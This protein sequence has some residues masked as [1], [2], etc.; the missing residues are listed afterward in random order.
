MIGRNAVLRIPLLATCAW[1]LVS[2]SSDPDFDLV[3]RGGTVYDGTGEASGIRRADV[4]IAG[5]RIR[6]IGDLGTRTARESVDATGRI[7]APG[8]IDAQSRSGLTLLADGAGESH[9]RQGI[10]SEILSDNSPAPWTAATADTG[11]LRRY[12]ITLDWMGLGGY[13]DRLESRGTAINV[14]SLIPLSLARAA[15]NSTS[16]IDGAMRE[17]AFGLVDDVNADVPELVAASIPVGTRDGMVMLRVDSA[18]AS[19][20]D[21]VLAVGAH[22]HRIVIAG[23]S[24]APAD[25]PA[26]EMI[27][28]M[29]R[30]VPRNV[31]VYGTIT[32]YASVAGEPDATVRETAK[33]GGVLIG[34]DSAAVRASSAL[35]D[36]HPAAFGAFPR[37]VG[38]YVRDGVFE[39]REAVRRATSVPA[40]VFQIQQRGIIRENYYADL[41]VFDPRT[42][43]D[44]ATF[45]RPNQYPTGVDYV[46]VNGVVTLTPRGLTG[47]RPGHALLHGTI[48]R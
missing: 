6:Q 30:A 26:S 24:H 16:F 28:R 37:F 27:G 20:D 48:V 14:G 35:A 2:C 38:P 42:I 47:S 13:F 29:L 39:L 33:F 25:H 11:A 9:L 43:A 21:G 8:F 45:E 40:S 15:G 4:G 12:G 18:A 41:V 3:I 32:P 19:T 36:T 46:I 23:L 17:G 10:T 22:A 5:D 44:R 31:F 34:T 1:F 7:V